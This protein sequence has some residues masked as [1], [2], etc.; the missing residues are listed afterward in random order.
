MSDIIDSFDGEFAFLSNFY[1]SPISD[2][3]MIMPTVEHYFQAAKTDS[4]Y[5]YTI[6][7]TA[8]TPGEAKR[9]GRHCVLRKDWEE[10]KESVM[11]EALRKK[12]SD[13]VLRSKLLATGNRP[14][15]EGNHWHDNYWGS[16]HC[17]RCND[18]GKNVLGQILMELRTEL[19]EEN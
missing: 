8:K 5:D 7:A 6:I 4:M 18:K 2:G 12:F 19:M 14:L 1:D 3:R 17:E 11:R 9:A 10:V 15:K 16:C 13:P